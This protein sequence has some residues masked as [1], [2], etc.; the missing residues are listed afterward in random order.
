MFAV[1]VRFSRYSVSTDCRAQ[2]SVLEMEMYLLGACICAIIVNGLR[3]S[4]R[5]R[6]GRPPGRRRGGR[7]LVNE[8]GRRVDRLRKQ[9]SRARALLNFAEQPQNAI[10][11]EEVNT[12]SK[13]PTLQ[14][15]TC[16]KPYLFSQTT[17]KYWKKI[18]RD[19]CRI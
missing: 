3:R 13:C 5:R 1:N 9:Q 15:I 14:T 6:P 19:T 4:G 8:S 2:P 10:V 11:G 12:E 7:T 18:L 16:D 17:I